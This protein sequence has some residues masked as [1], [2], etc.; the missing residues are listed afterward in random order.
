MP[1]VRNR[2]RSHP[3]LYVVPGP[4][5]GLIVRGNLDI[6]RRPVVRNANGSLSTV[7]SVSWNVPVNLGGRTRNLE[8]LMPEV[9]GNRVVSAR[10]ALQHFQN[11]GEHLGMFDDAAHANQYGTRLHLWYVK[12][13]RF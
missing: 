12:N 9:I 4:T 2:V 10:A 7:K 11:T 3:P 8:V 6:W 5:P 1:A 13:A